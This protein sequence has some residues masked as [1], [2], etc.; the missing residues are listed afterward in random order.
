MAETKYADLADVKPTVKDKD[1][2]NASFLTEMRDRFERCLDFD[3]DLRQMALDDIKFTYVPGNQWDT[4]Q[5]QL[6]RD[7]PCYEFNKVRQSVR[8]I[9][10]DQLQNRP[11]IKV[12][13]VEEGDEDTAE[14]YEGIIRNIESVSHAERAY[15]NAFQYS[16]AGGYGVWRVI[17]DYRDD[18]DFDQ[19]I[20][21]KA[22]SNPFSAYCD[23]DAKE[24]DRRDA[25][26]WFLSDYMGKKAFQAAYPDADMSEFFEDGVGDSM[27]SWYADDK[28]RICEYWYKVPYERTIAQLN[29]GEVVDKDDFEKQADVY[30]ASGVTIV[31]EKTIQCEKVMME[32]V[33]G[34]QRLEGPYEWAGKYIPIV[35]VWGDMVNIEGRDVW[36]GMVRFAKD[37]QRLFN[38]EQ[39]TLVELVAKQPQQPLTAPAGAIAGFEPYY[40]NLSDSDVPVLPYNLVPGAPN[41]GQP[42]R[43]GSAT[44]PTAWANL[45]AMSADNIKSTL[46]IFDASLGARSNETSGR[47][48]LARQKEGDVANFVYSDNLA[49]ALK[50]TG[51]I[52]VDLIPKIYDT[53]RV[54]RIFGKDGAEKWVAINH[55]MQDQTGQ[56]TTV[57][58]LNK[59]K[60]DVVVDT[61]PSYTTQR[62]ELADAAMQLA[63]NPGPGG[64]IWQLAFMENADIPNMEK[65]VKA[66]RQILIGQGMVQPEEGDEPRQQP[67]PDPRVQAD[68][69]LKQAQAKLAEAKTQETLQTLPSTVAKNQ[70]SAQ[71]DT[72]KAVRNVQDAHHAEIAHQLQFMQPEIPLFSNAA[73]PADTN[74]G[75]FNQGF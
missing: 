19:D 66:F 10:G 70:A 8:Q 5:S 25:K 3:R 63:R 44:F 40:E 39:S 11:G 12:R 13:P 51:E 17:T 73:T 46:G 34:N 67:P 60:Y 61:G 15:D 48:I 16:C 69:V 4:Y 65:Y 38:F 37:A 74:G 71:E 26:F 58:D 59:G 47:A 56:W 57:N 20:Y 18:D 29:S 32:I 45:S 23:P 33:S 72:S 27:L 54:M 41:G 21:I 1:D 30:A 7:R 62:Q 42:S 55:G 9:T 28:V 43:V 36:S 14:I 2:P 6:R 49:K 75:T 64:L 31:R 22:V 52:L 53:D 50:Y 24:F 68:A 35:P